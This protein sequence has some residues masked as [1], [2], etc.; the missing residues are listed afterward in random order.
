MGKMNLTTAAILKAFTQFPE[1]KAMDDP[2]LSARIN[3]AEWAIFIYTSYDTSL[4]GYSEGMQLAAN[5]LT[6]KIIILNNPQMRRISAAGI[7]SYKIAG[8]SITMGQIPNLID[9][10]VKDILDSFSQSV[11]ITGYSTSEDVF[12]RTYDE[13]E[14]PLKTVTDAIFGG[15]ISDVNGS[16]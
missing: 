7:Q 10:Q 13:G 4:D 2:T 1:I 9:G 5:L 11:Q 15:G 14:D 16:G 6:E 12:S 3:Q 8:T